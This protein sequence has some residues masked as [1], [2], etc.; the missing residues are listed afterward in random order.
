MDLSKTFRPQPV[1]QRVKGVVRGDL[2]S[3]DADG[4]AVDMDLGQLLTEFPI[5]GDTFFDLE[6]TCHHQR[7]GVT[8]RPSGAVLCENIFYG[9]LF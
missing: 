7:G 3:A 5:R 1:A 8:D 9:L 2:A 4:F 6:N